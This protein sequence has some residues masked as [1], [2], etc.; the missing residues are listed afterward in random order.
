MDSRT[1]SILLRGV[2]GGLHAAA[3][4]AAFRAGISF[5]SWIMSAMAEKLA[6]D[7]ETAPAPDAALAS[8]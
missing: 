1:K 5:Q 3:R 2:D 4:M 6:A 8:R 7:A